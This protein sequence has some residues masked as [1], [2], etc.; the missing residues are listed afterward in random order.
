MVFIDIIPHW[1]TEC[2]FQSS[3][4]SSFMKI[5]QLYNE[6]LSFVKV[7]LKILW[8]EFEIMLASL[9]MYLLMIGMVRARKV[10]Y[11]VVW[12]HR[13]MLTFESERETRSLL[14]K[15]T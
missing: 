13:L 6:R 9:F 11:F 12:P 1:V 2:N 10:N 7:L 15:V 4:K 5:S 14:S 8:R 3:E